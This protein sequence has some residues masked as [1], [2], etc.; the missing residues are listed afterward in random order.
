MSQYRRLYL[1]G[2]C[3]FFTVVT[4]ARTPILIDNF[5]RLKDAFYHVKK[6]LPFQMEAIVILP[7][8]LHC[9]W[10]L[11]E[12][13]QDFSTRW[14]LIKHYFSIGMKASKSLRNEKNIWQNRFWEHLIRNEKDF[15]R[16]MD[17]IHYNPVKHQLVKSPKDWQ[18]GSFK[19]CVEQG[20]YD[21]NWGKSEADYKYEN[22]NL[23]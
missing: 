14:K 16:H 22:L 13:D 5:T 23:E 12:S 20:L 10:N 21:V 19:K 2:G 7:D 9:I 4:H 17:Y 15:N 6:S 18:Y 1:Q 3:Y 11:P 8:H